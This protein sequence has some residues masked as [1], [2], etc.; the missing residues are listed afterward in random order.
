MIIE[1]S[2]GVEEPVANRVLWLTP[3]WTIAPS[4]LALQPNFT[5]KAKKAES[6]S[7]KNT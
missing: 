7:E 5:E 2:I 3:W 4:R 6:L 1:H